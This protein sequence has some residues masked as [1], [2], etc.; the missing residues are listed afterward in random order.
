MLHLQTT[1][2]GR[3]VNKLRKVSGAVGVQAKL[4]VNKWKAMVTADDT[5][6]NSSMDG[7]HK[8]LHVAE[9]LHAIFL[10]SLLTTQTKTD[11]LRYISYY[12]ETYLKNSKS[13]L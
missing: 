10:L 4:V 7:K 3:T 8:R 1:G 12:R 5:S 9:S 11:R 6:G 2:I 13:T